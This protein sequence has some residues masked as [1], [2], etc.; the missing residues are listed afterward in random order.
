AQAAS[1][2]IVLFYKHGLRKDLRDVYPKSGSFPPSF[3]I[4]CF[5]KR[6]ADFSGVQNQSCCMKTDGE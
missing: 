1:F 2:K 5:C 3:L 6:P 4:V